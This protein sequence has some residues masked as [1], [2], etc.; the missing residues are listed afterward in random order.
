MERRG[1]GDMDN[2]TDMLGPALRERVIEGPARN[3]D[4]LFARSQ[5]D[6]MGIWHYAS[7]ACFLLP[8]P[9]ASR[10]CG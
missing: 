3:G 7:R 4:Q 1:T 8:P 10:P 2:K 6:W 9:N 5:S